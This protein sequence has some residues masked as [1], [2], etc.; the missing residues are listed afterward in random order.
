MNAIEALLLGA[1]Q[2]ATE[3]LPVS[4]S[5]HLVIAPALLGWESSL[6]F[7]VVVH[8]ATAMA[9][10]LYFREDL[11]GM[12][13]G[14]WQGIRESGRPWSNPEGRL[15]SL[16]ALATVPAAFAGLL[17]EP[18][19]EQLIDGEP[20]AAARLAA[21]ML[22]VTGA[23]LA[24]SERLGSRDRDCDA[25]SISGSLGIGLAQALALV[26][27]IS[28]SGSTIATGLLLGLDRASAARFSFLMSA[29]IVLGAG[30]IKGLDLV[31]DGIPAG[32]APALIIGFFSAFVVGYAS[33]AWLLGYLRRAPLYGFAIYTWV[34]GALALWMLR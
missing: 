13:F 27:G 24:I 26:P 18:R 16:V 1:L 11:K 31:R 21:G 25:L 10:L 12:L 6:T 33:I 17:L 8:W 3:F 30:L 2:G 20:L 4:S 15:L 9:V 32:E 28:R 22:F 19:F 29:P 34:V 7:D 23:V 5:G 14:A